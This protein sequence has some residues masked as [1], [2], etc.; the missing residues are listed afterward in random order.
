MNAMPY[1]NEPGYVE[2][3]AGNLQ[4]TQYNQNIRLQCMKWAML[5]QLKNAQ[6]DGYPFAKNIRLHFRER[7]NEIINQCKTW[8]NEIV[9]SSTASAAVK[10]EY[11]TVFGKLEAELRKL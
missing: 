8:V 2:S 3:A 11:H 1:Y 4:A 5:D 9:A 6:D 10:A 7:K